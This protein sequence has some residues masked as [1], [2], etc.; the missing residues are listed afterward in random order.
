MYL[1]SPKTVV[2]VILIDIDFL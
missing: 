1:V 2:T